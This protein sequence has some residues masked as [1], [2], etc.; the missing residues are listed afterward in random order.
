MK[1]PT[2]LLCSWDELIN[3]F[4]FFL[5]CIPPLHCISHASTSR[6][7]KGELSSDKSHILFV[8]ERERFLSHENR[9][10]RLPARPPSILSMAM[11]PVLRAS[12]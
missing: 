2:P 6:E 9:D 11:P 12:M 8:I 7:L 3:I 4:L 10:E 1:M 5:S